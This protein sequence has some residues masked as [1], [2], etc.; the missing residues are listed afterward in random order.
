MNSPNFIKNNKKYFKLGLCL[1][2]V[3]IITIIFY[4]SSS[5]LDISI[6]IKNAKDILAPFI[7]GI[8]IA[9]VLNSSLKF[10]ENKIFCKIK[11]IED[12]KN[13]KRGVSIATAYILLFSFLTWL[14]SYLIPEIQKS[15]L[16]ATEYFKNFD[17]KALDDL[18][19]RIP[20]Q[21]NTVDEITNYVQNFLKSF[22]PSCLNGSH[23]R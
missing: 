11:Y 23:R 21:E 7:Y 19:N 18:L 3:A 10:L 9:Y 5:K 6:T 8:G 1:L 22:L 15:V 17:V 20:L 2:I 13:V 12:R 4:R 14:I 16:D